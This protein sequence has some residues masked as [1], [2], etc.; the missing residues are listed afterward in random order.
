M[1]KLLMVATFP[2]LL[3]NRMLQ[4][5]SI[6]RN[7]ILL[8][9]KHLSTTNTNSW[10]FTSGG[11][12]VYIMQGSLQIPVHIPLLILGDPTYLL[13]TWLM[14]PYSDCGNLSSR[15]QR[16]FNYRVSRARMVVEN[17]FGH[18]KERWRSL[19]KR[20]DFAVEF[21][22]TYVTGCCVRHSICEPNNDRFDEDWLVMDHEAVTSEQTS[23]KVPVATSTSSETRIRE[24]LCNYFDSQ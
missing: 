22:P 14:K 9:C 13:T 7:F 24:R 5:I 21:L 18:L 23:V 6:E 15:K 4:T 2:S 16:K 20:N 17:A 8:F 11:Q 10:T 1:S 12:E 19:L 3:Q